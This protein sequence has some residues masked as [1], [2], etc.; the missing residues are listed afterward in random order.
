VC[1][2]GSTDAKLSSWMFDVCYG[3]NPCDE[4]KSE[5]YFVVVVVVV[6]IKIVKPKHENTK[7]V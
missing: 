2:A 3:K 7:T 5:V 1:S 6:V 4:V